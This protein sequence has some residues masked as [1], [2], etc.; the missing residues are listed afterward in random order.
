M[1]LEAHRAEDRL[2][3]KV[4]GA[5]D[6]D[7]ASAIRQEVRG[8][9]YAKRHSDRDAGVYAFSYALSVDTCRQMRE[10]WGKALRVHRELSEWYRIAAAH[11]TQQVS[12]TKQADAELPVLAQR[13]P[14]F[15]AWLKPDQRVTARWMAGLYRNAGLLADEVGTG[16]TAGVV[17][18][19]VERGASGN[20]L[21][22]CPKISVKA[23]WGKEFR[24]H[25]PD[26]PV[27]LCQGSRKKREAAIEDFATADGDMAVLVIV[28][29]MLRANVSR[30]KGRVV[31]HFGYQYPELF[32]FD[33]DAVII[34]E[35]QKVLGSYDV[36]KGNGIGEGLRALPCAPQALRL[37]V[38]A[39]PFGK[40]GKIEALFGTLHWLWPDEHT[41][42]W[43]WLGRFFTVTDERVYVKSGRGAT[44]T[45]KRVAGATPEQEAKLWDSLGPRVLRRTMEEVSPEHRG[46]KNYLEVL[47]EMDTAQRV[48][49][50][51]FAQD[52]ELAVEG[53]IIS[54][55]GVLDFLTRSRQFANGVLRM[56]GGRVVYTGESC[57]LDRMS[58]LLE[59]WRGR[60]VVI[61]SQYNEFLDVVEERLYAE[62]YWSEYH[63]YP[64]THPHG[65]F[66]RLDG[67]TTEAKREAMMNAFQAEGGPMVFLLN[68]QAGGVS[69]TL[70]AADAMF[71][72]DEMD[73][74]LMTQLMGR[75]FRRGRVHEVFY[76]LFRSIGTIDER[77]GYQVG[78]RQAKQVRLL[79]GP[80]GIEYARKLAKYEEE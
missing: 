59:K 28:A 18:G 5:D 17:A 76:Y 46:L 1:H 14:D 51:K 2:L 48:Q 29:E 47:C 26:V 6:Y 42:K 65:Q 58:A 43:A 73:A 24:K 34:D 39:T 19:L 23:V 72:L 80:R 66:V 40:G 38:S 78:E 74:D 13:Y 21:I 16:K 7:H 49:Y 10:A 69:I 79:D 33:W 9:R 50:T 8:S 36:V 22:V 70:D 35:S 75:I 67:S 71:C 63:G 60:K 31:E 55:V 64:S 62:G 61:S 3:L 41:S 4:V 32:D 11:R 15:Y 12:I 54:T 68:G 45:V 56:A 30:S 53:G 52:A 37:A 20:V 77:I 44:K 57:K 25:L 27:F